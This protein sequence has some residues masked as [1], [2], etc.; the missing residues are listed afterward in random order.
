MCQTNW[1]I[2]AKSKHSW[3]KEILQNAH[4]LKMDYNCGMWLDTYSFP[5][6]KNIYVLAS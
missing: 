3:Q 4:C 5:L 2:K 1:E 6:N